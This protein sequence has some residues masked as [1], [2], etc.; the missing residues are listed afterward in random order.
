MSRRLLLVALL[1]CVLGGCS[2]GNSD[3]S[4]GGVDSTASGLILVSTGDGTHYESSEIA[5]LSV[6]E[7][8][9][10]QSMRYAFAFAGSFTAEET[11]RTWSFGTQMS[12]AAAGSAVTLG[13]NGSYGL[14]LATIAL[15]GE[16]GSGLEQQTATDGSARVEFFPRLS[17]GS[18]RFE[19][20]ADSSAPWATSTFSG[21]Y[22][23][24]CWYRNPDAATG[25][26]THLED[27]DLSS[28]FCANAL[29]GLR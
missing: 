28:T 20:S 14:G 22:E 4:A 16:P 23:I 10:G 6:R 25:G 19:G 29:A 18:M 15:R 17:D 8:E 26:P 7:T 21:T 3:D 2:S 1:T 24:F 12:S 27:P 13:V 5:V 11:T 9:P